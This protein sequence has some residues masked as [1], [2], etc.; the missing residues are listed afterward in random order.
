MSS[1]NKQQKAPSKTKRAK[2]AS[3][4]AAKNQKPFPSLLLPPELRN[5]IYEL[6]LTD[7]KGI[8]LFCKTKNYRRT[9]TRND[10]TDLE[11]QRLR[12]RSR[13]QDRLVPALLAVN[14]Q[15]H[16]E[17]LG[18]LYQQPIILSDTY[19]LHN[20]LSLIGSNR[21]MVTNLT[22]QGWGSGRGTNHAMNVCIFPLLGL[23]TNLENLFLDCTIGW[24]RTPQGLARQIYRDG[25]YFLEAYGRAKGRKDAGV[26]VLELRDS[27]FDRDGYSTSWWSRRRHVVLPEKDEF[28]TQF[29]AELRKMLGC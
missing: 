12:A 6:A 17:A 15:I 16:S 5:L 24:V 29:Q 11:S 22:V 18:Y 13:S 4:K 14:K 28:R 2:I 8:T 7:P 10:F 9:V 3:T 26:D 20:F 19:A 1:A 21:P 27:N 23:C 25:H